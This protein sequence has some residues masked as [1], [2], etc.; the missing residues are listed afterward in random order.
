MTTGPVAEA[1][2][3]PWLNVVETV[4]MGNVERISLQ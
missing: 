3:W 2:G 1:G 4:D